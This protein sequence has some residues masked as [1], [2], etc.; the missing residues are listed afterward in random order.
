M[1]KPKMPY[2][3]MWPELTLDDVVYA[4]IQANSDDFNYYYDFL[5]HVLESDTVTLEDAYLEVY[6]MTKEEYRKILKKDYETYE[7]NLQKQFENNRRE[8][9]LRN[10]RI[11]ERARNIIP[12]DKMEIF[13]QAYKLVKT[14]NFYNINREEDFINLLEYLNS[15]DFSL[16]TAAEMFKNMTRRRTIMDIIQNSDLLKCLRHLVKHGEELYGLLYSE[17]DEKRARESLEKIRR[18]PIEI[19]TID[20]FPTRKPTEE[21]RLN[22]FD[23]RITTL[24]QIGYHFKQEKQ[25]AGPKL[26]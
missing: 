11:H 9:A 1:E 5:G 19:P 14:M 10:E 2:I 16:D 7:A 12:E 6:G 23:R 13:E 18:N 25:Q 4:L 24:S 15:D 8:A 21:D 17:E 26:D 20:I 22:A 3:F